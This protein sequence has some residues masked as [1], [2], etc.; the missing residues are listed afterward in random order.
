VSF[1]DLSIV[2]EETLE[3]VLRGPY[4]HLSARQIVRLM[5]DPPGST[6]DEGESNDTFRTAT[7][8][9]S[10]PGYPKDSL[11]RVTARNSNGQDLDFYEFESPS[12]RNR[13]SLVLTAS[14]RAIGPNGAAQRIELFDS[15]QKRIPSTI[16]TNGNGTFTIQA[17]GLSPDKDFYVRVGGGGAGDYRVDLQFSQ[18]VTP[19]TTFANGTMPGDSP[20]GTTLYIAE[21]MVFGFALEATGPVSGIPVVL[22]IHDSLGNEVFS[23]TGATGDTLSRVTGFM[24]PGEYR[25]RIRAV[26]STAPI[27]FRLLG[28]SVS[29][30]IGP[31][32]SDSS[33]APLYVDPWDPEYYLYPTGDVS[34]DPYLWVY[35]SIE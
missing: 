19:L 11:Y 26:E 32:I 3:S 16:L 23:M 6:S 34:L 30:P 4:D 13:Q 27:G 35:W 22:S 31:Q 1:E 10:V 8:L 21:T 29:D 14:V 28:S 5:L 20:V 7:E 2:D 25:A 33:S 24:A 17:A 18:S 9:D 15:R 12:T